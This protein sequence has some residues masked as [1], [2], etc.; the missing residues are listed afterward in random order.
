MKREGWEGREVEKKERKGMGESEGKKRMR[1]FKV[2]LSTE[3]A[4]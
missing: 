2:P 1:T 3:E 4:T